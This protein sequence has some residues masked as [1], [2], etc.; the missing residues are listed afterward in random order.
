MMKMAKFGTK[1]GNKRWRAD[2]SDGKLLDHLVKTK[3]I[4]AGM[5]PAA[6]KELYPRFC[7]YKTNAFAAALRRLKLKYGTNVRGDSSGEIVISCYL[8]L[9]L[10]CLESSFVVFFSKQKATKKARTRTWMMI[11]VH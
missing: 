5:T 6:L 9:I 11:L 8:C 4:S 1:V 10:L 7:V 3:K 2:S